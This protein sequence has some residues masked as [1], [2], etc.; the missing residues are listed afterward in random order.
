MTPDNAR[1]IE[2]AGL[3][4]LF[5]ALHTWGYTIVGPTVHDGAIVVAEIDSAAELPHGWGVEAGAGRYRVRRRSDGAV[6]THST[7]PRSAKDVLHPPRARLWSVDRLPDGVRTTGPDR[8]GKPVALF[9]VHPCDVAA[10]AV[11]DGVLARG[12]H[13]DPIYTSRRDGTFVVVG[14][15]AS[16]RLRPVPVPATRFCSPGRSAVTV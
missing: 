2:S 5:A 1:T 7:G 6:F 11:L 12:A 9:G 3:D 14:Y 15:P 4:A 13:P 8:P 16:R 10:L